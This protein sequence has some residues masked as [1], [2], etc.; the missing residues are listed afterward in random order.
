MQ[1]LSLLAFLILLISSLCAAQ[2]IAARSHADRGLELA[3]SG[4]LASAESE[5][6]QAVKLEP[7]NPEFLSTLGTLL[8]MDKKLDESTAA[9]RKAVQLAP[10]DFTSRRY[11]A[12][13][14][15]Q[16]HRYGEAKHEL[17]TILREHP[18]DAHS[19]LLL[20]MV[21]ENSGDYATAAKMLSSVP[22]EVAKQ[23]E[24]LAALALSYYRLHE[25]T[26]ARTTLQ[27]L[28]S[29]TTLKAILLGAEISDQA[30][31]YEEAERLLNSISSSE[32]NAPDIQ[33]R[34]ATVQYHAG[35]FAQCQATLQPLVSSPAA[36]P[37]MYNQL[38]WCYHR[39]NKPKEATEAFEH[40]IALTPADES[41]Y[42]DLIKVLEAHNFLRVALDASNRAAA[43]FP[44]SAAVF[45]LKGSIESRLLQFTDAVASYSHALQLDRTNA[46]SI[47]G[48]ARAQASAGQISDATSTFNTAIQRFPKDAR[49]KVAYA[50]ILLK[51]METGDSDAKSRAEQ[52]LRSA[53]AIDALNAE[54]LYQLGNIELNDG[55][56]EEARR[57]LEQA[58]KLL[59]QS[60]QPH[61]ALARAY[62][63]LKRSND[64][65]R[66]MDLYN[67][68]KAS[69]PQR[70]ESSG[71][72][73]EARN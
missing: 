33:F 51:Q 40:A 8:A 4:D 68:L 24:S 7:N 37:Q 10:A 70:A 25:Q 58:V 41:N 1:R 45:N 36:T 56:S 53:I 9:F 54:A 49:I 6:R 29:L 44:K 43:L 15:W 21:S 13:N 48:L 63:R 19:R 2:S 52:L 26:N 23:P 59:P 50:E 30:G 14:L 35:H 46:N 61:F 57:H 39:L 31:D 38:G 5:L 3:Q 71:A 16:L 60:S 22:D 47:L 55:R 64:A 17:E 20:G 34:R 66:E 69:E 62:R 18:D 32:A 11:L 28:S 72:G 27:R 42:V 67:K 73:D 65:E 12:A